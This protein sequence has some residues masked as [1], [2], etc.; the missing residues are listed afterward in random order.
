MRAA[1]GS[2]QRRAPA[3]RPAPPLRLA[4]RHLGSHNKR[5]FQVVSAC[6]L[7]PIGALLGFPVD[8]ALL[9]AED[10]PFVVGCVG[11]LV[12]LR[13]GAVLG[14]RVGLRVGALLGESVVGAL[15]GAFVG[16]SEGSL[17]VGRF[18]GMSVGLAVGDS[19]GPAV[20]LLVGTVG[21]YDGFGVGDRVGEGG[22][23][24]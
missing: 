16:A 19:E 20:G 5:S 3:R 12:G 7:P 21:R 11:A 18:V 9:G 6:Y 24:G 2:Q 4:A 8:G 14:A 17:V 13:V 10:G 23:V 1:A 22:T 15:L